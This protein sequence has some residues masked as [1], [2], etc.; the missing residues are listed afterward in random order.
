MYDPCSYCFKMYHVN[1][2][3]SYQNDAF[4]LGVFFR[5]SLWCWEGGLWVGLPSS[6]EGLGCDSTV[7]SPFSS[8]LTPGWGRGLH[9]H[10]GSQMCLQNGLNISGEPCRDREAHLVSQPATQR[11]NAPRAAWC[12]LAGGSIGIPGSSTCL[13]GH[14]H[15]RMEEESLSYTDQRTPSCSWSTQKLGK[16]SEY[17]PDFI[18]AVSNGISSPACGFPVT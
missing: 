18:A 3:T 16:N 11:L 9:G 6:H 10:V 17:I 4:G 5:C 12:G 13:R 2:N 1:T 14:R 7:F 8:H 15:W